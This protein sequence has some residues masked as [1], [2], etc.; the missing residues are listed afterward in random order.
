MKF[1][2]KCGDNGSIV[3]RN[4]SYP[5]EKHQPKG[6]PIANG[7]AEVYAKQEANGK[8]STPRK[9]LSMYTWLEIQ[10]HNHEA[11]QLVINCKVYNVSSW[12]DRHPGGHQVLNHCAGED[13]MDVFRAMHPELDIVQLYLKPLLIGELA[14]GEPS[15]ERHKNSQLVKDFQ[16]LWSIAEAMNM[17][18]ANLGFF[19]LHFVQIL[20]LEVLAWLIVYHFGSGWPVTMF[21]S[22]LLTISQA[23]SS[24]LQ[25][26][27]GHLSIFR[28]SKWNHVVHK[29]VMCHLK[30]LSADRWNYWHFEQH[31][32]PNIYPKDP[33]IDTDPL[34]LLGDSQP[35]KYGKKK[36]K[37]IN[38][39]EQHLYFY[40]VW[41]PLFMPV[42][43][44]LPSMQAM[45]L[46]RYWVCF[47]LQDITWVSSF[48]IYFITFGL[49]YGIF[50]TMLL[51][52]LVKFL[53]SPWI[54]YVTQ[55][56][57]IT[58]RMSTEENRDW[59][60]TQVLATC[61]TESFFND[62][63]GHLN[64]QIEHHLF[65]T[66]PRHNYHKV[67]PL[68]RSLCAKHGLHYVNKPM[69]RAFGDIVRALKKS[70]ALWA[71]AY[72]E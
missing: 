68:V 72:Y 56:S 4:Q 64:F 5:G 16:E 61:N 23:S 50:G 1:E 58:M 36:I 63:T 65:P 51:I 14:P 62:F 30:G 45:Y 52:Y 2:E 38:Y 59:L 18:H 17:F 55:M 32:K 31:V 53:E 29:F 20:I 48:Y 69:L 21:I 57:H 9:S 26:D 46:Q 43:L 11:D 15:Q 25:H 71:D 34:F 10:R 70:A 39:E 67:A 35:V 66:M 8:C 28:K 44:K 54:V 13:A 19:F 47:S 24:F 27:A 12:A 33:D 3:G 42:Y 7:E 49:Y 60:T 40:K 6:K 22:F 37:Y 41:L